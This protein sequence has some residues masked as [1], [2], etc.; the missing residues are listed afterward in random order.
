MTQ[1]VYGT[2]LNSALEK[3]I[4][5]AETLLVLISPYIKLHNRI[6]DELKRKRSMQG[7]QIFILYGKSENGKGLNKTDIAFFKDFS[8]IEIRYDRNLHAKYYGNESTGLITSM[9][10]HEFSQNNNIEAGVLSE[11]NH[12]YISSLAN[13]IGMANLNSDASRFFQDVLLNS[14]LLY[15]QTTPS[16]PAMINSSTPIFQSTIEID[17]IDNYHVET[18]KGLVKRNSVEMIDDKN[19]LSLEHQKYGFCIRTGDK[20]RF[21]LHMPYCEKAHT[22]WLK[23]SNRN[24]QEKFCHFSGEDSNGK[25][26]FS[27]PILKK[28]WRKAKRIHSF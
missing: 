4:R 8:N 9:N 24:Y 5:R 16:D 10:L 22:S 3:I 20:I 27:T 19:D 17:I 15:K 6:K 18:T 14:E 13:V 2:D 26:C 21:D 28:N 11:K 1:F 7:L 12:Q 25:T 23:W